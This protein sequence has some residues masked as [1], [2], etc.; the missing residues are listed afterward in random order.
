MSSELSEKKI[1]L[2]CRLLYAIVLLYLVECKKKSYI[3]VTDFGRVFITN[4][5]MVHNH[6][7]LMHSQILALL[8]HSSV[9]LHV[10]QLG[11]D[12]IVKWMQSS[13]KQRVKAKGF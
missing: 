11:I 3:T 1:D 12:Y 5:V 8:F 6:F 2:L 9:L 13:T 10:I 7:A 4:L